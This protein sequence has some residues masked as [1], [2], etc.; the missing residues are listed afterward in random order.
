MAFIFDQLPSAI[1]PAPTGEPK[2][3]D[4]VCKAVKL[5]SANFTTGGVATAVAYIPA[6]ASLIRVSTY[7]KTTFSGNG[8][9]ALSYTL[10]VTGTAAKFVASTSMGITAGAAAPVSGILAATTG[11]FQT[12]DP[13]VPTGDTQLLFT[14]TATTGNP[15]AGE[16]YL[17]VEYV[18]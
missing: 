8:V 16:A 10:G 12:Y 15:T 6:D 2:P 14:G 18:R 13:T 7:I 1:Y 9:T 11:A 17:L 5:T 4:V 3:K